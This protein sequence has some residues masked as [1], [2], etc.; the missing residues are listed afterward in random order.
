MHAPTEGHWVVVKRI[1][2]YLKGTS[3]FGLH[4]TRDS[5]LS[6]HGFIDADWADSID[7][8]KSMVGYIVFVGTT[9]IS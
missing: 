4:L 8:K 9:P 2:R 3:S 5:A 6:L 7:N 1:L